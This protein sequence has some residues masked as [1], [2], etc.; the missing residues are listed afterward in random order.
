MGLARHV[1]FVGKQLGGSH[2]ER[3]FHFVFYSVFVKLYGGC[4]GSCADFAPVY[5]G[6]KRSSTSRRRGAVYGF[7]LWVYVLF[8]RG[9][10]GVSQHVC[11]ALTLKEPL[12]P[13]QLPSS[14]A[15]ASATPAAA[16]SDQDQAL[17]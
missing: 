4:G 16:D 1:A 15:A 14:C 8:S 9:V 6:S 7:A 10:Q 12:E 3:S 11:Q 5:N 2:Q 13:A 17:G